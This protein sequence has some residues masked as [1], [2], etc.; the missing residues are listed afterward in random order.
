MIF[1][2]ILNIHKKIKDGKEIAQNPAVFLG[3]EIKKIL[4]GYTLFSLVIL[5]GLLV[6]VFLFGFTKIFGDPSGFARFIFYIFTFIFVCVGFW[7][8]F[9]LKLMKRFQNIIT[10]FRDDQTI[11]IKRDVV[12]EKKK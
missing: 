10:S 2:K 5:L 4:L 1:F 12:I 3:D 7:I 8:F 9:I 11:K 6:L